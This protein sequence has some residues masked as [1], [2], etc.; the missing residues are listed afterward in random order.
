MLRRFLLL[1]VVIVVIGCNAGQEKRNASP[2]QAGV[3]LDANFGLAGEN[4]PIA[5]IGNKPV[6]LADVE[7]ELP[8]LFL[9]MRQQQ[10]RN[11]MSF[12]EGY[13]VKHAVSDDAAAAGKTLDEYIQ[14]R[15]QVRPIG[16][17]DLRRAKSLFNVQNDEEMRSLLAAHR[18]DEAQRNAVQELLAAN[19]VRISL[20][21]PRFHVPVG[22]GDR[23]RGRRDAPITIVEFSDFSCGFCALASPTVNRV[24]ETYGNDVKLVYKHAPRNADSWQLAQFATCAGDAGKFWA[25]HDLLFAA[26]PASPNE[27]IAAARTRLELKSPEFTRCMESQATRKRIEADQAVADAVG[28]RGTPTFFVNGMLVPATNFF[29]DFRV[30]IDR[31]RSGLRARGGA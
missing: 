28:V 9:K 16:E 18:K 4:E 11:V 30:I 3:Q 10:Y 13:L 12:L 24:L 5:W 19:G 31:E 29:A 6:R 2:A 1:A 27:A 25:A 14:A 22:P 21:P 8:D 7:R 20:E 23:I 26:A 17:D 15:M